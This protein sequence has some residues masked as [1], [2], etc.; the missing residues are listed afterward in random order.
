V[1]KVG[2]STDPTDKN[3]GKFSPARFPKRA[4]RRAF[5][6][7]EVLVS[8]AIFALGAVTLSLAYLN[9]LGSYRSLGSEQQAEEDWKLLRAVVL[10]EAELPKVEEGGRITLRDGRQLTW[11]AQVEPTDVAD[12]FRLTLEAEVPAS[13]DVAAWQRTQRLHVLR[14]TWSDPAEREQLREK[15]RQRIAQES[16]R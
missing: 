10:T 12:L 11:R 8:L 2:A 3:A 4:P 6:L 5:T 15:T 9:V 14:P 7:I 16:K 13:G 1:R